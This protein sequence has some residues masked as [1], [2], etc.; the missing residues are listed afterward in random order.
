MIKQNLIYI[1][2]IVF[3]SHSGEISHTVGLL[4]ALANQC[5]I[6]F[7]TPSSNRQLLA[8]RG[9]DDLNIRIRYVL[10]GRMKYIHK[11]LYYSFMTVFLVINPKSILYIRLSSYVLLL[12]PLLRFMKNHGIFIEVNSISELEAK[13]KLKRK[14][15]NVLRGTLY[16]LLKKTATFICVSEG[17]RQYLHDKHCIEKLKVIENGTSIVPVL[18]AGGDYEKSTTQNNIVF[19]GN[20]AQ[21]QDIDLLIDTVLHNRSYFTKN[22][23]KIQIYGDGNA[24][25]KLV[26]SINK[27]HLNT[28]VHYHGTVSTNELQNVYANARIGLLL[29]ERL[30]KGLYQF[31]PL[32]YYEYS[33]FH[34]PT[35]HLINDATN[36]TIPLEIIGA[37][38]YNFVEKYEYAIRMRSRMNF[39]TRTWSSV[40]DEMVPLLLHPPFSGE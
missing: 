10:T 24:Q 7:P 2:D 25:T 14:L 21:W 35:I 20:I 26:E 40:V 27:F 5:Q 4:N 31:S 9:I 28:I 16:S 15:L 34:L 8:E 6:T 37:D 17:I 18:R 23:L 11:L 19:V 3:S 22:N 13:T 29:D 36:H 32:K 30:Y 33:S 12:T 39:T 1:N 38:K